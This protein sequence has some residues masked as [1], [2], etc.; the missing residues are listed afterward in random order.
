MVQFHFHSDIYLEEIDKYKNEK[1]RRIE[2]YF[3]IEKD[4]LLKLERDSLK[5]CKRLDFLNNILLQVPKTANLNVTYFNKDT[6]YL[7][8]NNKSVLDFKCRM[9]SD[10]TTTTTTSEK[11]TYDVKFNGNILIVGRTGCCKATF[12]QQLGKNK[13]FGAEITCFLGFKNYFMK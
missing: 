2:K 7:Y 12:I 8:Q 4:H 11:Y 10:T 6:K 9:E 13:L 5:K 1:G 3:W